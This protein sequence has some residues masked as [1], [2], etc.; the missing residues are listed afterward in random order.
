MDKPILSKESEA[1]PIQ[2]PRGQTH[3]EVNRPIVSPDIILENWNQRA[4][5][6]LRRANPESPSLLRLIA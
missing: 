6:L 3:P 1:D 4:I 2:K 5:N